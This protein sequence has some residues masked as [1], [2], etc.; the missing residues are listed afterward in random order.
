LSLG[1]YLMTS[2]TPAHGL[3]QPTCGRSQ[4]HRCDVIRAFYRLSAKRLYLLEWRQ[5]ARMDKM[6]RN[7]EE[8]RKAWWMAEQTNSAQNNYYYL[9]IL[10]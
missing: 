3:F 6:S 8:I 4:Y 9:L 10:G 5:T 2:V 7:R 1:E